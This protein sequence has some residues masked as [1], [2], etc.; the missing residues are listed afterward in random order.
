MKNYVLKIRL[1][2]G[3]F[4]FFECSATSEDEAKREAGWA[5][6]REGIVIDAYE[7]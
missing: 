2:S 4:D 1:E 6:L 7:A 3:K 5:Y